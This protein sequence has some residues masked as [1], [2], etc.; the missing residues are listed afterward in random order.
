[1]IA[2]GKTVSA[3]ADELSL[4]I[5]TVSTHKVRILKKMKLTNNSELIH[6][7]ITNKLLR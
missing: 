6:F 1:M 5:K 4:S 2:S 7:A 3:I